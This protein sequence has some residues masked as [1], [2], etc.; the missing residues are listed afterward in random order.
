M[1]ALPYT[2]QKRQWLAHQM[3]Q[4]LLSG[5]QIQDEKSDPKEKLSVML[6]SLNQ[7]CLHSECSPIYAQSMFGVETTIADLQ[8]CPRLSGYYRSQECTNTL[9]DKLGGFRVQHCLDIYGQSQDPKSNKGKK[10]HFLGHPKNGKGGSIIKFI[11]NSIYY[12]AVVRD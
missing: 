3:P 12:M 9:Q 7:N 10:T 11:S 1:Y 4:I 6:G 5:T 8:K 2:M